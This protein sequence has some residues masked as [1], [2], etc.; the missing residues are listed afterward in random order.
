MLRTNCT[1]GE[2]LGHVG[3]NRLQ[4]FTGQRTPSPKPLHRLRP[5]TRLG[6]RAAHLRHDQIS[7]SPQAKLASNVP[8]VQLSEHRK[9]PELHPAQLSLQHPNLSQQPLI[10]SEASESI[11]CSILP[12]GQHQINHLH[13]ENPYK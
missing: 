1:I 12:A 9:L 6:T 11:T 13:P 2:S 4:W 8:R 3:V 7:Q 5:L 10:S